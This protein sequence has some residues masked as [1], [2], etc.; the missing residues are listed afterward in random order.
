VEPHSEES[1][2]GR[3]RLLL[4]TGRRKANS[5]HV[6]WQRKRQ[7]QLPLGT[8]SH[9]PKLLSSGF[10]GD[11][12]RLW[13]AATVDIIRSTEREVILQEK[14]QLQPSGSRQSLCATSSSTSKTS[15]WRPGVEIGFSLKASCGVTPGTKTASRRIVYPAP[16]GTREHLK[17]ARDPLTR[18]DPFLF[19]I[20][21]QLL[22][23]LAD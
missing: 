13:S 6:W 17:K 2:D 12:Q 9:L 15:S 21:I 3:T 1:A 11:E 19:F 10:G 4:T 18:P 20:I 23:P 7:K 16:P 5:G 22:I 8:Y 14:G